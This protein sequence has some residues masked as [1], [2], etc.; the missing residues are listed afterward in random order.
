[1]NTQ[2]KHT[3]LT[4]QEVL[5][6]NFLTRDFFKS[7]YK[8][9]LLIAG[10]I[11]LYVWAGFAAQKQHHKLTTLKKELEDARFTQLTIRTELLNQTR[12]SEV[13][14]TLKERGSEVKESNVPVIYI[15][16]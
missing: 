12:Q 4:A 8:L 1:M 2:E 10:L 3:K 7:Q 6:G 5:N 9:L 14:K 11:F 15:E 13:S 16:N